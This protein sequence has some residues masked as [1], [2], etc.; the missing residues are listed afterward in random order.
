MIILF[1][2]TGIRL[3]ELINLKISDVNLDGKWLKIYG[4]GQKERFVPVTSIARK[5]LVNYFTNHRSKLCKVESAYLYPNRNGSAISAN[6]VEQFCRR[7]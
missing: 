4:K 2:D 5:V 7:H 1:L 3:S 6:A